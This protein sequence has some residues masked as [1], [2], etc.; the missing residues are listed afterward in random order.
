[1]NNWEIF[2]IKLLQSLKTIKNNDQK[3]CIHKEDEAFITI[4]K[5]IE[6]DSGCGQ[7]KVKYSS[8]NISGI[9]KHK[10]LEKESKY[11]GEISPYELL[12]ICDQTEINQ[13]IKKILLKCYVDHPKQ[14]VYHIY[15]SSNVECEEIKE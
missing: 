8:I 15:I 13:D 11:N 2:K 1:M 9:I 6:D 4:N 5:I 14:C 12:C 3:I 10:Y 7:C